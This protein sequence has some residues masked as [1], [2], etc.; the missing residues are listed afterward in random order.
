MYRQYRRLLLA[1]PK[2]LDS[3]RLL[4]ARVAECVPLPVLRANQIEAAVDA[5]PGSADVHAASPETESGAMDTDGAAAHEEVPHGEAG[6]EP[7]SAGSAKARDAVIM[8]ETEPGPLPSGAEAASE[9]APAPTIVT[10]VAA[11]SMYMDSEVFNDTLEPRGNMVFPCLQP[12]GDY[13]ESTNRACLF[14]VT[15]SEPRGADVHNPGTSA[16]ARSVRPSCI[17]LLFFWAFILLK[18]VRPLAVYTLGLVAFAR[19]LHV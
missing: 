5:A 18:V 9:A 16:G 17:W 19:D 4:L 7:I 13:D 8:T 3:A 6:Q 2:K 10:P 14:V 12:S 1:H 15:D 11:W